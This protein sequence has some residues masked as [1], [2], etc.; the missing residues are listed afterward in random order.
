MQVSVKSR[1]TQEGGGGVIFFEC[2]VRYYI[3][4]LKD[5][6]IFVIKIA[7]TFSALIF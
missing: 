4:N 1:Y 6:T 2:S 7:V 5:F 3:K